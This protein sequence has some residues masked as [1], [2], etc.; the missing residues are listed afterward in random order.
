MKMMD[1]STPAS[2]RLIA[3]EQTL[4]CMFIAISQPPLILIGVLSLMKPEMET[5][6]RELDRL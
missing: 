6:L 4:T 1:S 3:L 5:S 2:I